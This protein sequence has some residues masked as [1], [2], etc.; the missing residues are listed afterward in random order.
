MTPSTSTW[1]PASAGPLP[2]DRIPREAVHRL[3]PHTFHFLAILLDK[4]RGDDPYI[5]CPDKVLMKE[6]GCED[7]GTVQRRF[8]ELEEGEWVKRQHV[9]GERR[10][11]FL[12][13]LKGRPL[14]D[15]LRAG[16]QCPE[17]GRASDCAP[18]P[19][20]LHYRS[21]S[22]ETEIR[23]SPR[24]HVRGPEKKPARRPRPEPE[25]TPP[26]ASD[27]PPAP[28]A[29]EPRPLAALGAM[30]PAE[31]A[32]S[33]AA[34]IASGGP[35]PFDG[36]WARLRAKLEVPSA[37]TDERTAPEVAPAEASLPPSAPAVAPVPP[38][39]PT[40]RRIPRRDVA[41]APPEPA[42][43]DRTPGQ[44]EFLDGLAPELRQ[45]FD[46]WPPAKRGQVLEWFRH[47]LDPIGL[48]EAL[49][50]LDV[51]GT[52]PAGPPP[53]D[54]PTPELIRTLAGPPAVALA[55]LP[56]VPGRIMNELQDPG[57]SKSW[58]ALEKLC[59]QVTAGL[60]SADSLAVPLEKTLAALA[61]GEP[62]DNAGAYLQ[63][64]VKNWDR[65]FGPLGTGPPRPGEVPAQ[66]TGP[67]VSVEKNPRGP[68]GEA[69]SV[70]CHKSTRR[71]AP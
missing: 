69:R 42:P 21:R 49:R 71:L 10:I 67:R 19:S 64:G 51:A 55:I 66:N 26:V 63:A 22:S 37:P 68:A 9:Q 36:A 30:P 58:H 16:A 56:T 4:R 17:P 27:P 23:D 41:D 38:A 45:R 57:G 54:T 44:R 48:R 34:V 7:V 29:P 18:A 14:A 12:F 47:D 50:Q 15:A 62:I 33:P 13:E 3:T 52:A 53:P 70:R 61:R 35:N 39:P 32:T 31:T 59:R 24:A 1:S 2:W 5:I 40:P 11:N 46:A 43:E 8:L 6:H 60:R 28:E 20:P 65:E 25:P